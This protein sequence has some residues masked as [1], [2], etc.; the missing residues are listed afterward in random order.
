[1]NSETYFLIVCIHFDLTFSFGKNIIFTFY[2]LNFLCT[3]FLWPLARNGNKTMRV[4]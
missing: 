2:L 1:M 4:N 3:L